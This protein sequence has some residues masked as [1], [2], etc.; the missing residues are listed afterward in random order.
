MNKPRMEGS[1]C[2][3]NNRW[4]LEKARKHLE[5][6]KKQKL[7]AR[8]EKNNEERHRG[9]MYPWAVY[10]HLIEET[11]ELKNALVKVDHENAIEEIADLINCGEILA[12]IL[13]KGKGTHR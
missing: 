11:I 2:N 9:M 1:V 12:A 13:L 5:T 10:D 6:I 4:W 3:P 7:W 8:H